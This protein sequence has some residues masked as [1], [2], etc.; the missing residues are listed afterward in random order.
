MYKDEKFRDEIYN[1]S[2]KM[3]D[4]MTS[5]DFV[6]MNELNS[7]IKYYVAEAIKHIEVEG[8]AARKVA[9]LHK[10]VLEKYWGGYSEELQAGIAQAYVE[11]ERFTKHFDDRAKFTAK[12]FRDVIFNYLDLE[13]PQ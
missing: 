13:I 12:F 7:E 4:N 11:D 8:E 2:N 6:E 9:E 5:E 1:K 3:F 10:E